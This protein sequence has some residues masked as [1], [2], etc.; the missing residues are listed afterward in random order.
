VSFPS[1][2]ISKTRQSYLQRV[3]SVRFSVDHIEDLFLDN[4]TGRITSTPIVSGTNALL[5]DKEILRVVN[6]FVGT[7][8]NAVENLIETLQ[9]IFRKAPPQMSIVPSVLSLIR[10]L[11]EYIGYRHSVK[12]RVS[13]SLQDRELQEDILAY[14]VKENILAITTLCRELLQISILTYSMLQA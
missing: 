6:V 11:G 4:L 8:L 3:T 12:E 9:L 10:S 7:G 14:L 5:S 1:H 2:P 13:I